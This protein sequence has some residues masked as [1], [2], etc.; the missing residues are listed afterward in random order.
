[1]K[2]KKGIQQKLAKFAQTSGTIHNT[3]IP[4]L[5]QKFSRKKVYKTLA[6]PILLYASEIWTLIKKRK[7]Y[8]HQST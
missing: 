6:V 3:F 1:M 8:F 7:K 5:V 4:A 2:M